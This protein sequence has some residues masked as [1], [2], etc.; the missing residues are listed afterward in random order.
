MISNDIGICSIIHRFTVGLNIYQMYFNISQYVNL[1]KQITR[2][3]TMK[4]KIAFLLLGVLI[5]RL[6]TQTSIVCH[7][8]ES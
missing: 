5:S 8:D 2:M 6:A 1:S 3:M 7:T 4:I